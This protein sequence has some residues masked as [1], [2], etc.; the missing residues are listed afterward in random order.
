M[1]WKTFFHSME[2][3]IPVCA[4]RSRTPSSYCNN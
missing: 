4:A 2:N 3:F 1:L